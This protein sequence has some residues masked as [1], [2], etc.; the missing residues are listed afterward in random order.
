MEDTKK[1]QEMKEAL[2]KLE[3]NRYVYTDGTIL[4]GHN[5]YKLCQELDYKEGMAFSLLVLGRVYSY[6]N[7]YQNAMSFSF[8]AINLAQELNICDLQLLA[9]INIGS[10]FFDMD[11][12]DKSLDYYNASLRI[13]DK[14][15][16]GKNYFSEYKANYFLSK[17]Y[18]NI[19]EVHRLHDLYQEA[20][21]YYELAYECDKEDE[22]HGTFGVIQINLG[23]VQCYMEHYDKALEYL[24]DSIKYLEKYNY[25]VGLVEAYDVLALV[26]RKLG[27]N[28][29]AEKSFAQALTFSFE[30]EYAYIK[31]DLYIHYSEFLEE[32]KR[33]QEAIDKLLTA[34]QLCEDS[35]LYSQSMEV[36][37]CLIRF[38]EKMNLEQEA[39]TYYR[40]YFENQRK[41]EPIKKMN[42]TK[43]FE[44]KLKFD[45]VELE[46]KDILEK[47]EEFRRE[48]KELS[49]T[50]SNLSAI[51]E[52]GSKLTTSSELPTIYQMLWN[53]ISE[54]MEPNV[55]GIGLFDENTGYIGYPFYIENN[56]PISFRSTSIQNEASMAAKCLSEKRI[57]ILDDL[58]NEYLSYLD[59]KDYIAKS[60]CFEINSVLFCPLVIDQQRIGVMT[61]QSYEKNFFS[62]Y[63]VEAVKA[64]A[65]YAAIAINHAIKSKRLI[66]EVE[67][68]KYLQTQLEK[69][70]EQ[71]IYLSEHD[72]L[73]GLPNKRKFDLV[74]R[75]TWERTL[76]MHEYM[77]VAIFDIDFFKQFNDFYGHMEGD[78]CLYTVGNLM[79]KTEEQN[80]FVSR[81]GGDEFVMIFAN[82]SPKKVIEECEKLRQAV[83]DRAIPHEKSKIGV[84]VTI[85]MGVYIL[86][87][88]SSKTIQYSISEADRALY[89]AKE[90]GRNQLVYRGLKE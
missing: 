38:Y 63:R 40:L 73:T 16:H 30:I 14:F 78:H 17:I 76:Q 6:L 48:T 39:F 53:A 1:Q 50:I 18:T 19:G 36:C 80:V 21:R 4:M 61:I 67:K 69:S 46:K 3:Q 24:M 26:Y 82:Q 8:D 49:E 54:F 28:V 62:I 87:P 84:V 31:V 52:M 47:S 29:H 86:I 42:K 56:I 41:Q 64:Y 51:S 33:Y 44:M 58:Q 79:K 37:R 81:F 59:D 65:S 85:T 11:D 71:L 83:E 88:D 72:A 20:A 12:F 68:R 25:V 5:A 75:Q 9:Y 57:I 7:D 35:Q 32:N 22:F 74:M 55:F 2:D 10:I 70:N 60:N 23:Y 34:Y 43:R 66:N 77:A 13:M 90:K 27:D 89:E 15:K 45:K